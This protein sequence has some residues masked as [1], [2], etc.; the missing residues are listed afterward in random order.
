MP[1]RA[2]QGNKLQ[3]NTK[4]TKTGAAGV[5]APGEA[6]SDPSGP[7]TDGAAERACS[8]AFQIRAPRLKRMPVGQKPLYTFCLTGLKSV[9]SIG[10]SQTTLALQQRRDIVLSMGRE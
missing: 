7:K 1:S 10:L 2:L 9:G 4:K 5:V 8:W 6:F 3:K